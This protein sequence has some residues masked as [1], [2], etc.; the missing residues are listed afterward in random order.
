M[1]RLLLHPLSRPLRPLSRPLLWLVV[2]GVRQSVSQCSEGSS[3]GVRPVDTAPVAAM[4][5][6]GWRCATGS[7]CSEGSE[8]SSSMARGVRWEISV[9]ECS[10][11]RIE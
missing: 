3:S 8:D 9:T 11:N 10:S 7:E 2:G 5:G 6:G 4:V 1:L